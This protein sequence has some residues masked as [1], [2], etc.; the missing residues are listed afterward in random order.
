M[1]DR[2]T[3]LCSLKGVCPWLPFP[4][5]A[6]PGQLCWHGTSLPSPRAASETQSFRLSVRDDAEQ[7]ERDALPECLLR[8]GPMRAAGWGLLCPLP[9]SPPSP[10]SQQLLPALAADEARQRQ[11]RSISATR[12]RVSTR[13]LGPGAGHCREAEGATAPSS[14]HVTCSG[15]CLRPSGIKGLG[16]EKREDILGAESP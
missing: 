5:E 15:N 1:G 11:H 13:K 8:L 14:S 2:T 9:C 16:T 12:D 4:Y 10:D 3:P 7:G 6:P